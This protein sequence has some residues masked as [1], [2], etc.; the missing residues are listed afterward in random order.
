MS[1]VQRCDGCGH[2]VDIPRYQVIRVTENGDS[3]P[4][5]FCSTACIVEW[6]KKHDKERNSWR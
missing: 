6:T 3:T 2:V 5:D 1:T 4:L